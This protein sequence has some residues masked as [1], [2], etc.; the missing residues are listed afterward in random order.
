LKE[1]CTK[2]QY[3]RLPAPLCSPTKNVNQEREKRK[4]IDGLL[5]I[6]KNNCIHHSCSEIS[7]TLQLQREMQVSQTKT[8]NSD[9][10]YRQVKTTYYAGDTTLFLLSANR[11]FSL[12][13]N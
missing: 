4:T 9:R 11:S 5:S 13:D 2:K 8:R 6:A 7:N 3:C 10:S 12:T 1:V